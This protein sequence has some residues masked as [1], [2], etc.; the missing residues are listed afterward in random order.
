MIDHP[1][2]GRVAPE[3]GWVP[4]PR[5]LLRRARVLALLDRLPRGRALEVGCGA[6]ALLADLRRLGFTIEALESSAAAREIARR[7]NGDAPELSV[8]PRPGNDWQGR[9][10]F[11][12]AFEVLEHI[13]DDRAALARWTSWIAP[14]GHLLLSV[15]AHP[16]RWNATDVWAGHFRRY[17]RQQLAERLRGAGLEVERIESYG[18]P[19]A[20]L[21][22][23]VRG[24][25]HAR[26]LRRS[27]GGPAAGPAD[28]V[29]E[30]PAEQ[31]ASSG[32]ERST[33]TRLYPLQASWPGRLAMGLFLRLQNLFLS[34]DL[35][36]G[37]LAHA[38]RP[39]GDSGAP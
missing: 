23:P 5:Y 18:V 8:S 4:A 28:G 2:Y 1:L 9:F 11:V 30:R 13:E 3:L 16:G 20:D 10:D 32:V 22:H 15:P 34:T 21:L 17:R 36:N 39:L 35:G 19:L 7:L 14:G 38:R 27:G 24:W 26:A 29:H 37:Y 25:M 6:G 12:L 33:E 31:T